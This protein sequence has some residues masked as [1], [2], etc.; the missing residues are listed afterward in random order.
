[1]SFFLDGRQLQVDIVDKDERIVRIVFQNI[2]YYTAFLGRGNTDPDNEI[3]KIEEIVPSPWVEEIF[4]TSGVFGRSRGLQG[5]IDAPSR[6]R[7]RMSCITLLFSQT[8]LI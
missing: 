1:M 5:D 8:I 3:W 4:T 6:Y 2:I 7:T